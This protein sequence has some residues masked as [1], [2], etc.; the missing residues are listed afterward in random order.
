MRALSHPI[1]TRAR[2]RRRPGG[3]VSDG[4]L[5][6][7][8]LLLMLG[9]GEALVR[10]AAALARGFGISDLAIG[11]LVVAFG[12]SSPEL[13]VNVTAAL[14]GQMELSFGNVVGS[15]L[16]NVGMVV[17]A[18]GMIRVLQVDSVVVSRE[19]PMM[20]LATLVTFVVAADPLIENR[21]GRIDR[22]DGVVLLL[23]FGVFL[24]YTIGDLLRQRADHPTLE[25]LVAS[26]LPGAGRSVT[27]ARNLLV[28][29]SGLGALLYGA[30]LT[31]DAAVGLAR[32]FGVSEVVIGISVVAVGTSLPE[33]ATSLIA[34][35]RG[36][37]AIAIGN[38]IGSNIFNLLLVFSITAFIRP[39]EVPKWGLVDLSV[40]GVLSL[41][42]LLVSMS[43]ARRILRIEAALLVGIYVGYSIWRSAVT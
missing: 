12:T 2:Y 37:L 1:H 16:A 38:V 11:L 5:L 41:I 4:L 36:H 39:V 43:A 23:F 13:A 32:A 21:P 22:A 9:G 20:L 10:G 15:N 35:V 34:T 31:V 19:I 6:A 26:E 14:H 40:V 30:S 3:H 27:I 25:E 42:L 28:T 24:Y 29:L 33:L 8:G 17:G 18:C 7:V